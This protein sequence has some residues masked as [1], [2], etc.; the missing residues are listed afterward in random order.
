[1]A[2]PLSYESRFPWSWKNVLDWDFPFFIVK[3]GEHV[4]SVG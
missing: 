4:V 3:N 1:M 2:K